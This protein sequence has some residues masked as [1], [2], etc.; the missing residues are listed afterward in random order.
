MHGISSLLTRYSDET[1]VDCCMYHERD[2]VFQAKLPSA[3]RAISLP[4]TIV[5]GKCL[6]KNCKTFTREK[7]L[8]LYA[9]F[10]RVGEERGS[11]TRGD[12]D[13]TNGEGS[14]ASNGGGNTRD[15]SVA[16]GD[17]DPSFGRSAV[18]K[19]DFEITRLWLQNR[20]WLIALSHSLLTIQDREEPLRVDHA[21]HLARRTLDIC[22]GL[23]LPAMEAH[24]IGF[25][26]KLVSR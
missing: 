7:A 19:A 10:T 21:L 22:K 25:V 5:L 17:N 9:A 26:L 6:G 20:A 4:F 18:Q 16:A 8:E 12:D 11:S 1:F 3:H 23:P 15:S 14:I 2:C 13:R 24:G